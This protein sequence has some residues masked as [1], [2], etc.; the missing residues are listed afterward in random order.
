MRFGDLF[1]SVVVAQLIGER[2]LADESIQVVD[3]LGVCGFARRKVVSARPTDE[4]VDDPLA[5]S[6]MTS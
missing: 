2:K 5:L 1:R 4:D 3:Y 6:R